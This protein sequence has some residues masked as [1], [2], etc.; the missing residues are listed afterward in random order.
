MC[1]FKLYKCN[2]LIYSTHINRF[3]S[4]IF[5]ST[6]YMFL[7]VLILAWEYLEARFVVRRMYLHF[8]YRVYIPIV[9]LMIFNFGSYWIPQNALP[10]RV[11]LIMITF[12]TITFILQSVSAQ[13]AK[14]ATSTSLQV[15]LVFSILL[16]VVAMLEY[17]FILWLGREKKE[18]SP[19]KV[20]ESLSKKGLIFTEIQIRGGNRR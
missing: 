19:A 2:F 20:G 18:T 7:S 17:L 3:F 9:L 6:K 13:T 12:L 5:V 4:F 14:A 11:T 1:V 10:A 16:V 15:F 8:I